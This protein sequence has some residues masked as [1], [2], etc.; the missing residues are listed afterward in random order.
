M[1]S[2]ARRWFPTL[3][4]G[5]LLPLLAVPPAHAE[6][7]APG[8]IEGY[9]FDACVAPDQATMDAWNL[10]SPYSAVG[11]YVSGNSRYC[12]DAYQR[13]LSR[14]WVA[15]NASHGWRFLPIHVGYQAPCF[16]N[17]P[18]S[19]VQK[20]KMSTSWTKAREQARSDAAE[21]IA[22]L[23]KYG[24]GAGSV[25]YLDI[26]WYSRSN[27][28]CNDA[29]L[30]FID[31]W[32]IRLHEAG[33]KSGL[34]SS[35]SAAIQSVDAVRSASW[36]HA[37]DQLWLA[38]GN[39]KA[40][41]DGG[42]YLRDDGWAKHQRVHQYHLDV[43]ATH[44]GK[45]LVIDKNYLD[46]GHGS[47]ASKDPQPCGVKMSFTAYPDLKVGSRGPEVA[48]LECLLRQ[49]TGQKTVNTYF[50]TQT[51]DNLDAFRK[52][53]GWSPIGRTTP[54]TWTALLSA[55]KSPRVLKRGSV[56]SHVWRLQRSLVAA[57]YGSVLT[58]VFDAR[59]ESAVRSYRSAVKQPAYP[60]AESTLWA[61]LRR[62]SAARS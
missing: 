56:G 39:K 59:T 5:L 25:G 51:R 55:E 12:H 50:G 32:T 22:A 53:L 20:K 2:P 10:Y 17:N 4:L 41:T 26:E 44:G 60:T 35:A 34:Y 27:K 24:F 48:A 30:R 46:T 1:T 42:P 33:Y 40:D 47:R 15:K 31:E 45:R 18:K 13:N 38:W 62:G 49:Q 7:S 61:K 21:N 23:K 29:V 6:P 43:A 3:L 11:I 16:S 9:G 58:G 54:K 57:G 14:T 19:R 52:R 36:F 37:P 28:T 8:S